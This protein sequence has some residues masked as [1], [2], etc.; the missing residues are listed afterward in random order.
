MVVDFKIKPVPARTS[1]VDDVV[2]SICD[3]ILDGVMRGTI[4]KGDRIPSERELCK[5]LGIGRSTLRE[6]IKV[7]IMLGLLEI[8]KGQGT[9]V[10]DSTTGFYTAP[11]AWGFIIGENSLEEIAEVRTLLESESAYLAT[12]RADKESMRQIKDAYEGLSVAAEE[13]DAERFT[14]MDVKFHL[15]IAQAAQNSAIFQM[16]ST[17]RRLLTIW[18]NEVLVDYEALEITHKEHKKVYDCMR[19]G[20]AAGARAAMRE[21]LEAAGLR[22]KKVSSV[23]K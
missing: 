20:D 15:A 13:N 8:K 22:L 21:H 3:Y 14:E 16:L 12:Q 7:L 11:L 17:I 18:I 2:K 1:V 6:A 10:A 4:H 23:W 5:A 9:F 19:L